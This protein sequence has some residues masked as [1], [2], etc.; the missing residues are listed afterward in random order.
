MDEIEWK[1]V[2]FGVNLMGPSPQQFFSK[3]NSRMIDFQKL[4][5]LSKAEHKDFTTSG[6]HD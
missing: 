5:T 2:S 3:P 6:R 4:E 1:S